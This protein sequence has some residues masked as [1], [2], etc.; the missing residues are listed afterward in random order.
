[1]SSPGAVALP[2]GWWEG[3]RCCGG[4]EVGPMCRDRFVTA[5]LSSPPP[6]PGAVPR[7]GCCVIS[8][9]RGYSC[10]PSSSVMLFFL[11]ISLAAAGSNS[12][13]RSRGGRGQVTDSGSVPVSVETSHLQTRWRPGAPRSGWRV[14]FPAASAGGP[15][16]R[17]GGAGN[18][19]LRN[20]F[21]EGQAAGAS[22][23]LEV[24]KTGEVLFDYCS[25]R[26]I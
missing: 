23:Q 15:Q 8:G 19:G 7:G 11:G 22:E 26:E 13:S 9:V 6:G 24:Q 14:M 25:I 20:T 17:G 3:R 16:R 1:M 5:V 2:G 18:G 12:R 10:P 4:S 21:G